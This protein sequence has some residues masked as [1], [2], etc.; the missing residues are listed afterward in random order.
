MPR[1][2]DLTTTELNEIRSLLK[3][4]LNYDEVAELTGRTKKS[5]TN[6]VYRYKL[7]D[8]SP[9][10]KKQE[11][12]KQWESD[13][14]KSVIEKTNR[15]DTVSI[16]APKEKTLSDF[17]KR[18]IIKYLYDEGYR[19]DNLYCLVKQKVNINDIIANG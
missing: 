18:Q 16:A 12:P 7:K 8:N 9:E 15:Q 19:W 11:T 3:E 1:G 5:V 4:G 13:I 14:V 17:P 10:V 6:A 2:K